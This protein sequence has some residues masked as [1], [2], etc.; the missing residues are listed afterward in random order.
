MLL[1]NQA[2][3]AVAKQ[4]SPLMHR[5]MTQAELG[6]A[7]TL[8]GLDAPS[9]EEVVKDAATGRHLF[10]SQKGQVFF[11]RLLTL[12]GVL[13]DVGVPWD[14]V[15]LEP[16][17]GVAD[18][19][20]WVADK[21]PDMFASGALADTSSD[22]LWAGCLPRGEGSADPTEHVQMSC[23]RVSSGSRRRW[24]TVTVHVEH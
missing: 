1:V 15:L 7:S 2:D 6:H 18:L 5:I 10:V 14:F 20:Q 3:I 12:W 17:A 9:A 8:T 4:S 19:M 22:L 23:S 13:P 16:D 11:K 24:E 21:V